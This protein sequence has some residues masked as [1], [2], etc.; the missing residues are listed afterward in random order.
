MTQSP[1]IPAAAMLPGPC[2]SACA[3][4][5]RARELERIRRLSVQQRVVAALTI[6]ARFSWIEPKPQTT[7]P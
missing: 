6:G 3:A 1:N 4:E 5:S 2:R 7:R